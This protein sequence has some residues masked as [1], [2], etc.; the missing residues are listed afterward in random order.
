METVLDLRHENSM[1]AIRCRRWPFHVILYHSSFSRYLVLVDLH[2]LLTIDKPVN[3][4]KVQTNNSCNL[5]PL[6]IFIFTVYETENILLGLTFKS[7]IVALG[8][9]VSINVNLK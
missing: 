9:K 5:M 3:N 1:N 2:I 7:S 4:D 8:L 6:D